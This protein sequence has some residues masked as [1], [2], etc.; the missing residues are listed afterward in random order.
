MASGQIVAAWRHLHR[1]FGAGTVSGLS[2]ADLLGRFIAG[3]D[4]AAFAA[5]VARH[6]PMVLSTCRGVLRSADDAEDAFQA[7][8]IVLARK[9]GTIWV[10]ES[11]GGWLHR[12]ARRIAVQA[13]VDLARRRAR[14]RAGS[15]RP[16]GDPGPW[17]DLIPLLHE[18]IGRLPEK[19]RA[20][21]VLCDL[22]SLTRD[23]AAGQLGWPP[24]TV[25]G[26]LDRGRRL[27]R[28]RMARRG[29]AVGGGLAAILAREAAAS[30]PTALAG[31]TV[32][33]ATGRGALASASAISMSGRMMRAMMMS[34][35][36]KAAAVVLCAGALAAGLIPMARGRDPISN[37]PDRPGFSPPAPRGTAIVDE[38]ARPPD[39][40]AKVETT[41]LRGRVLDPEGKPFA[42]AKVYWFGPEGR[43]IDPGPKAT[44]GVDG[45]FAFDVARPQADSVIGLVADAEGFGLG[46]PS[47][48]F[49]GS[50]V[51]LLLLKD[52]PIVGRILD[53][54]G[55]PVVGARVRGLELSV[56]E[57][58][59]DR[60]K[61]PAAWLDALKAGRNMN[62][63][64][65]AFFN[66]FGQGRPMGRYD[67]FSAVRP[68]S[69][70]GADG[71]FRLLGVGVGRV[72]MAM[73]EGP[74]IESRVVFLLPAPMDPVRIPAYRPGTKRM[75][76][77]PEDDA[78]FYGSTF[79]HVAG[80]G[81]AVEGTVRDAD[82]GRPLPGFVLRSERKSFFERESHHVATVDADGRYRL[83]GLPEGSKLTLSALPTD[84]L[85][86]PATSRPVEV[87]RGPGPLRLDLPLKRGV[88]VNG[89]VIDRA[90]GQPSPRARVEYFVFVANPNVP[91]LP[92]RPIMDL[93]QADAE[94][95]FR[96]V[97]YPGRGLVAAMDF[98]LHVRG[99]GA[100]GI[101]GE[102]MQGMFKTYPYLLNPSNVS[103]IVAIDPPPDA[104]SVVVDLVL[105][106]GRARKGTV[107]DPDGRPLSG[108]AVSGLAEM[109]YTTL[110]APEFTVTGL[111][112]GRP[113]RVVFRHDERKLIGVLAI[114]EAEGSP[115]TV[116]L[117]PW[118][119]ASGRLVD[120]DGNPRRGALLLLMA[121]GQDPFA[122][123]GEPIEPQ[124]FRLG[125]DGRF[126]VEGLIPG[127]HYQIQFDRESPGKPGPVARDLAVKPGEDRDLGDLKV[128]P[129]K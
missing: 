94:G 9:A 93:R 96:L 38:P 112:P 90:T 7:T 121:S 12:V 30:V 115:M 97:A 13:S 42:G 85:P 5:L 60:L 23:E 102:R 92:I 123:G 98:G 117:G 57:N 50:E 129:D 110:G 73:I 28:D 56:A 104:G 122:R 48:R 24:G 108:C 116:T 66:R 75:G 76:L 39:P 103:T 19:Y 53:L 52:E 120:D 101:A 109:S 61:G 105:E 100:E 67:A 124:N 126:R 99:F 15:D 78:I 3:R 128:L 34:K 81:R 33:A 127:E 8:F 31:S 51:P 1:I 89:R 106:T 95:R 49:D 11:L 84:D 118:G 87:G 107:L 70:T 32:G 25:A 111:V 71:K 68:P 22:G 10:G 21:I 77:D 91:K 80:P 82:S 16:A 58:V 64:H 2:D 40:A 114:A 55:R 26:R 35:L 69:E 119:A 63:K 47:R 20:P 4:E 74:T 59:L 27:L 45:R 72:L 65:V 86:Y 62:E 43:P 18:E 36:L 46:F 41:S 44:S 88:W 125:P 54:Q 17:D 113:R 29:A 6:G 14:E 79:D 37:P 83:G